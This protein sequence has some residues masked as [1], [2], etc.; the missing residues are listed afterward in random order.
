MFQ[1]A[2]LKLTAW[3]L[4]IIM[5]V[6]LLFSAVIYNNVSRQIERL[7]HM[8]NDRIRS[9]Q[10]KPLEKEPPLISIEELQIQKLQL[11]Y[12]LL[13]VNLGIIVIAGGAG[14]FL[15]GVTLRPIKLMV[16][17]QN[18]FISNASH[19]LRTPIATLRAEMEGM[20]L[21]KNISDKEARKLISSN[22]EDLGTLQNLSD[23]LLKLARIHNV[24]SSQEGMEKVSLGEIIKASRKKVLAL[25]KKKTI[26]ISL[27][28]SKS[29]VYG[30]KDSLVEM[31]VILLDNAIKY[32]PSHSKI[33]VTSENSSDKVKVLVAD[34]GIGI[35]DQDLPHIFERF[36][37]ADK[38]R[39]KTD[40]YGLGLSIAKNIIESHRGSVS[41][42]SKV[43]Q[44][45]V[46]E[47]IFPLISHSV[48]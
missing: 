40:G 44:G 48:C 25:A 29:T 16:D 27:N 33:S 13:F 37:R 43:D 46:F 2:R 18:D 30:N 12:T 41:V 17:E 21:E 36:F 6:S 1:S 39:S 26:A 4:L 47:I 9:F 20:L 22:L 15:A 42:S 14:Y 24:A 31:F 23:N 28:L 32:S 5:L 19:E 7:M 11:F 34:Q 38:S 45:S 3:Y 35:S 8:Q 10:F